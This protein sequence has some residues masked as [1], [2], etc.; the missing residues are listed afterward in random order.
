MNWGLWG[1]Q[2]DI[3][4]MAS[5]I[6][7]CVDMGIKTFDHADIYGGYT[8]EE[9]FGKAFSDSK[10]SRESLYFISKC[11]I[12]FPSK[13]RPILF[14]YYTYTKEYIIAQAENS[15]RNLKTDYL[16]LLLLHRPSPLMQSDEI[17]LAIDRLITEGKI[18]AFGVSNFTPSQIDL[19]RDRHSIV[20]NQI[21]C[22]LTHY[23]PIYNGTLDYHTKN[24]MGVMAWSP[25]GKYF[26]E[27]NEQRKR[28]QKAL[29]P[30]MEKYNAEEDELL[31]AWLMG[32]PANIYPVIGTTE[33]NRIK[34]SIRATEIEME[35]IDWFSLLVASQGHNMP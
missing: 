4:S 24:K 25:L 35:E 9:D 3:S 11:G 7:S 21:E 33:I 32:H 18:K 29:Q 17:G 5:L 12:Q 23:Q 30:L 6:D 16:D 8:T 22:S 13:S 26:G 27:K 10:I 2:L 15:L 31:L 34:K 28:I 1:K 20:C 14:N 19:I